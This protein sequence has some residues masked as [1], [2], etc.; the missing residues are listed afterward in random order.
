[1][2]LPEADRDKWLSSYGP[3]ATEPQ[4]VPA[5][6]T[7]DFIAELITGDSPA[8]RKQGAL[9]PN[10]AAFL[11]VQENPIE[12][13]VVSAPQVWSHWKARGRQQLQIVVQEL[14]LHLKQLISEPVA[15]AAYFTH[16]YRQKQGE[17]FRGNLLICDMGGGT[18]D[19]TLCKLSDNKVEVLCNAGNGV[20]GLGVAGA[21]F[22]HTLL[23]GK[24]GEVNDARV[25]AELLNK[26]DQQKKDTN[27]TLLMRCL[28]RPSEIP[29]TPI[30]A[31]A[32][33][34]EFGKAYTFN[35]ADIEEAF[36]SV[37]QGI[38]EVL[39]RIKNEAGL[40][41][42]PIDKIVLV[43]GF[44]RFPLVQQAVA[45][46]FEEDIFENARLIDLN[47][48][49][50]DEM[51]FAISYGACLVA[52]DVV[53]ISEKYD[54]T[55]SALTYNS[56]G[57]AEDEELALITAGSS[58]DSLEAPAYCS[59]PNGEKRRFRFRKPSAEVNI[60]IRR[61]GSLSESQKIS[62]RCSLTQI[63]GSDIAGNHW[64][65]GVRVD[66]SKIPYLVVK[67]AQCETEKYYPLSDLVP[68]AGKS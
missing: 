49:R 18:F 43:G 31:F 57:R 15:A 44:S 12:E 67:D 16:R 28:Q 14:G 59:W 62:K 21:H 61:D 25:M 5:Q 41:N 30:Y 51:A 47:T 20:C 64:Y 60:V 58:L 52:N 19:V 6:V 24:L 68:H 36:D 46:A 8:R 55:I 37:R 1:M 4:L 65:L 34:L 33:A 7:T 10:Q 32:S 50:P 56:S 29:I 63:P 53:Q 40:R 23:T 11:Q 42:Y 35:F 13:L 38:K 2:L 45:E 22:D 48:L 54:H 66:A 39:A 17:A 9:R 3:Y 27:P 26:L